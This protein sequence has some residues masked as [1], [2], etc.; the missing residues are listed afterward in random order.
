MSCLA[1]NSC[2]PWEDDSYHEGGGSNGTLLKEV[3]TTSA[4]VEGLATY[5]YDANGRMIGVIAYADILDMESYSQTIQTYTGDTNVHSVTKSYLAGVLTTTTTVNS[6]V[7]GNLVNM[8]MSMDDGSGQTI[9]STMEITFE[10]PCGVQQNAMSTTM[11]GFPDPIES[12]TTYEYTDVNC[13]SKEYV[14][15]DLSTTTTMDGKISPFS[16]PESIAMGVTSHNPVKI[17]NAAD[18]SVETITYTYNE[19]DYPIKAVHTF[20]Q[21]SGQADY[22]EEF[23]YY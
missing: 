18:G 5:T 3:H 15:G 19:Q 22:T 12:L 4:G 21:G 14:N 17:E 16:T 10:L 23:T 9:D 7:N 13:S 6:Q 1:L 11:P 8:T 20:S 2:D